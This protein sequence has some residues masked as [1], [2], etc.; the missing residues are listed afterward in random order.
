MNRILELRK[1]FKL[2]Q[3]DLAKFAGCSQMA[4]SYYE[5]EQRKIP[6]EV[7]DRLCSAF[8][9]SAD[10]LLGKSNIK[11]PAAQSSEVVIDAGA[12]SVDM[13]SFK[14]IQEA[15]SLFLKLDDAGKAQALAYLQF[16]AQQQ[17]TETDAQG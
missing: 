17:A 4:I 15:N 9:C 5:K 12:S 6:Y 7:I 11:N 16:L 10:Y 1:E 13:N 14:R 2:S 8:N 3:E